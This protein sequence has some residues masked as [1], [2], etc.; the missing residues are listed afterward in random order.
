[1]GSLSWTLPQPPS[2]AQQSVSEEQKDLTLGKDLYFDGDTRVGPSGDYV[3]V[4]G[5]EALRQSIYRRLLTRPG[6]FKLRPTYGV[7]VLSYVKKRLNVSE[8]DEL[9][10]RIVDQLSLDDRIEQVRDV[11]IERTENQIRINVVI[12]A[13]GE[14][15][16]FQP[17]DFQ[18]EAL[19]GTI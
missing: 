17:F 12:Q 18:P 7:G 11:Q 5:L 16:K 15:L 9:K 2:Q 19:A 14:T 1:M 4:R 10:G 3:L 13:A 8:L 6:E